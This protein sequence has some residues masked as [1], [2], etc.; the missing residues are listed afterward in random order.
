M[1]KKFQIELS[2]QD[3]AILAHLQ[4]QRGGTVASVFREALSTFNTLAEATSKGGEVFIQEGET[5]TKVISPS[6]SSPRQSESWRDSPDVFDSLYAL[7]SKGDLPIDVIR[8]L[9]DSD[10][11]FTPEGL[12]GFA[13]QLCPS[14]RVDP[15]SPPKNQTPKNPAPK[16]DL[17]PYR[18]FWETAS[19]EAPNLGPST[20]QHLR[21]ELRG[22]RLGGFPFFGKGEDSK[23]CLELRFSYNLKELQFGREPKDPGLFRMFA[24]WD[25][26]PK[27]I[28]KVYG[29][30]GRDD[31]K[32]HKSPK[33]NLLEFHFKDVR[34]E[35]WAVEGEP[36]SDLWLVVQFS[37]TATDQ[38]PRS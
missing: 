6:F 20:L 3:Q 21:R 22:F 19:I 24:C 36:L 37:A 1:R 12:E 35:T 23:R 33:K 14:C 7:Y 5:R 2:D 30:T 26:L 17:A 34:P 13:Q 18:T 9:L 16:E 32:L 11:R 25:P 4:E 10:P 29:R 31:E 38:G 15:D 8:A 28:L 27:L